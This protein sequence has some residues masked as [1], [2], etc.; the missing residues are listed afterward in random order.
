VEWG[1]TDLTTEH[2]LRAALEDGGVR[3]VIESV[4]A[5]PDAFLGPPRRGGR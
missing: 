4:D 5:G 2:L 3:R 1:N